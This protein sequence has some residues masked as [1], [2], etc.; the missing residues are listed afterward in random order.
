MLAFFVF[1]VGGSHC[2]WLIAP[3]TIFTCNE[4]VTRA[5]ASNDSR[6]PKVSM[7]ESHHSIMETITSKKKKVPTH[8]VGWEHCRLYVLQFTLRIIEAIFPCYCSY[9]EH[10]YL[11]STAIFSIKYRF[12]KNCMFPAA[13]TLWQQLCCYSSP[14]HR[15]YG[16]GEEE[17][18]NLMR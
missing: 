7:A 10:Q 9:V 6:S 12:G 2:S 3:F 8:H 17:K 16:V 1:F 13:P 14:L 4:K 18:E 5:T 15:M 11:C